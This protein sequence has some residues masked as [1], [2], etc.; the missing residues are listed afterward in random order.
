VVQARASATANE[1]SQVWEELEPLLGNKVPLVRDLVARLTQIPGI[2]AIALGGSYASGAAHPNSDIDLGLYYCET[3]PFSIDAVRRLADAVNDTPNPTVTDF[4]GWGKWVNGGAWLTVQG[5]RVDFIYRNVERLQYWIDESMRGEFT[6]D[7]YVQD[8]YGFRSYIYLGELHICRPLHDSQGMLAALKAQVEVYPSAL[9]R[10]LIRTWLPIAGRSF[11]SLHKA[12]AQGDVYMA[13]GCVTRVGA[14]LTQ[15]LFT[16][17]ETYFVTDK[18]ALER[19]DTFPLQPDGYVGAVRELLGQPGTTPA[20][21]EITAA[22]LEDLHRRVTS[23]CSDWL[24]DPE[25]G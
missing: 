2:A 5:Q 3:A 25:A 1:S 4:G 7:Y 19:I 18:G 9:K 11:Y 15:V 17:N 22:R 14:M 6:Q 10:K 20:E 23:L 16:L 21:L 12:A 24:R 13:V 8:A